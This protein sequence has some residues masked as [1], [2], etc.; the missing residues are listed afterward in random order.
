MRS[1]RAVSDALGFILVFAIVISTLGVVYVGGFQSID[2]ARQFEQMNNA[3]RAFEVLADNNEDLIQRGA[4]SRATEIKLSDASLGAGDVSSINVT[5]E[6]HSDN[7]KN[8][9]LLVEYEPI[10]YESQQGSDSVAYALGATFRSSDG[11]SVMSEDPP[12]V[13]TDDRIIIPIV[14]TRDAGGT[15]LAGSRTVLVR[16]E[17]VSKRVSSL[18]NTTEASDVTINVSSQRAPAWRNYFEE[19]G[20]MDCPSAVNTDTF[21][22]CS[23]EDVETTYVT[24]I[25]IDYEFE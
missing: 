20:A 14:Q 18:T 19:N 17:L 9:S 16:T 2:N 24:V 5:V 25:I 12:M 23:F 3:E 7:T 6:R 22:S 4:P 10:V 15:S 1:D 8:G 13:L 21:A 11:E